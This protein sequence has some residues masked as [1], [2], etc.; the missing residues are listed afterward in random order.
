M[1]LEI[2][3]EIKGFEPNLFALEVE[4]HSIFGDAHLLSD[5]IHLCRGGVGAV[6]SKTER[7]TKH[8]GFVSGGE[9]AARVW[10]PNSALRA[11][12]NRRDRFE[13]NLTKNVCARPDHALYR[14]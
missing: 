12:S 1:S 13:K 9:S 8:E 3:S 10:C 14:P 11:I 5:I 6:S 7:N 4:T 2:G